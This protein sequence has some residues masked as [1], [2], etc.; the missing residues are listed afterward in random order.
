[1]SNTD[2]HTISGNLQ[3]LQQKKVYKSNSQKNNEVVYL[4]S[5]THLIT[6]I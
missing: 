3:N 4:L 5:T 6:V 2:V 1:M